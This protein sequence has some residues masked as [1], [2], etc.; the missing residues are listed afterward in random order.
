MYINVAAVEA[1]RTTWTLYISYIRTKQ[2][3][4][5]TGQKN[6]FYCVD[7]VGLCSGLL[8]NNRFTVSDINLTEITAVP[9][10][11]CS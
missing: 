1:T 10:I 4:K 5:C 7:M 9:L 6:V 2:L 3:Y 11:I 8:F